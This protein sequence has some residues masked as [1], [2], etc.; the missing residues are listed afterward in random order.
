M[1][2]MLKSAWVGLLIF[3]LPL[4]VTAQ[5]DQSQSSLSEYEEA[6]VKVVLGSSLSKEDQARPQLPSNLMDRLT[7]QQNLSELELHTSGNTFDMRVTFLFSS[8]KSFQDWYGSKATQ[9]LFQKLENDQPSDLQ[10]SVRVVRKPMVAEG[11]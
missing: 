3:A 11:N 1:S 8:L 2:R 10:F 6:Y 7:S 4:S 9:E 5:K